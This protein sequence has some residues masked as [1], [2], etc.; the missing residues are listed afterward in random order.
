M[1]IFYEQSAKPELLKGKI[2]KVKLGRDEATDRMMIDAI[3]SVTDKPI[4]VD[5][6]QGW[7]ERG[8]AL[9][10]IEWL[11]GRGVTFIEQPMPMVDPVTDLAV[12]A[13]L[14]GGALA[15]EAAFIQPQMDP[16][17]MPDPG[18]DQGGFDPGGM[19]MGGFDS[20]GSDF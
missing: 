6:N 18:Y 2:I 4:T 3:R 17:Y 5:A 19:D 12:D 15:A 8:A 16:G 13:A 20:G 7:K 9:K 10:M 1:Q 14:L 11:A